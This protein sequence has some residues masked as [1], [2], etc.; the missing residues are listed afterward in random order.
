MDWPDLDG[1]RY[2]LGP[3]A[4]ARR[5]GRR[6]LRPR[7]RA[8]PRGGA[9]GPGHRGGRPGLAD[10]LRREA[11]II[12][13]LEHPGIVPVHD[14]GTLPDGRVFYA[15][16]LVSGKRLDAFLGGGPV[17]RRA[18]A[19]VPA[20]LRGG[21]L[22]PRPRGHPPRPQARERHGRALRRGAGD[23][24]G[25]REAPRGRATPDRAGAS[26][27]A[28]PAPG[29]RRRRQGSGTAHG[30]VL[31]TPAWM[32]PEQARGEV[33][34]LDA[35]AD[36]YALGA[37]LYY[38]LTGRAPGSG[39]AQPSAAHPHVGR[40]RGAAPF[41][42]RS[43]RAGS[44][45]ACPRPL[46]AICLK[47]LA[48]EPADRYAER[49]PAGG[50]CGPLPGRGARL[51]LP[52]GPVAAGPSLRRPPPRAHPARRGLPGHARAPAR[53]LSGVRGQRERPGRLRI[54]ETQQGGTT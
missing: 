19:R 8:R 53:R 6:L 2:E 44:T 17:P 27:E 48:P 18:A 41:G 16:K 22:R 13:G 45:P 12:A 9:Q 15:M 47:A 38:M 54:G 4:G 49:R 29:E 30:T 52:G 42:R 5:H 24:L 26:G 10:R 1:T 37:I 7:P 46:E 21:R 14:V 28:G 50:R 39:E 31:G 51:G 43:P 32:A 35:R 25:G 34:R 40:L 20:R 11:R 33:E 23:G 3:G 36:V